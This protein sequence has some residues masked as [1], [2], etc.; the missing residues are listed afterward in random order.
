MTEL[1]KVIKGAN[2]CITRLKK[3]GTCGFECPYKNHPLGCKVVLLKDVL[4][5]AEEQEQRIMA[6]EAL[7]KQESFEPVEM[8]DDFYPIG[9]PLRTIGWRCGKCGERIAGYDNYCPNCGKAVKW[10]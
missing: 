8:I 1:E 9:D 6:I 5:I 2:C 10:E 3:S 7:E 4:S